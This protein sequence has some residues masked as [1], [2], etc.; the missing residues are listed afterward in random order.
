MFSHEITLY[1][2]NGNG[3]GGKSLQGSC[4]HN[5]QTSSPGFFDIQNPSLLCKPSR[6]TYAT[7]VHRLVSN[8]IF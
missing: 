2:N 3:G 4:M 8:Y 1:P 7:N 6:D 5:H